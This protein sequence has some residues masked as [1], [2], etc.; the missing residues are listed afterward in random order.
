MSH[1][2]LQQLASRPLPWL[3]EIAEPGGIVVSSRVRLAR[4]LAGVPFPHRAAAGDLRGVLDQVRAAA[5]AGDGLGGATCFQLADLS[6]VERLVL[7]ERRL[8]SAD[9]NADPAERAVWVT[10]DETASLMVNEEDHLRLQVLLPGLRLGQA[11]DQARRLDTALLARLTPAYR[12]DLGFLTCCPTNLGTGLRASVMLHL[13]GLVLGGRIEPAVRALSRLGLAVRG[14]FGETQETVAHFVQI[15]NQSSLG[16]TEDEILANLEHYVRSLVW[17][18]E[19]A[20]KD[21]VRRQ[22]DLLY[23]HV[24]RAYAIVRYAYCLTSKEAL[25]CFSALRFGVELGLFGNLT[26]DIIQQLCRELPSGHLQMLQGTQ[27][28]SAVRDRWRAARARAALA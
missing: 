28:E 21:L 20:R 14:A 12:D 13:P 9:L 24:G 27:P 18:E 6:L 2:V 23:D 5:K 15:S 25:D 4:N 1:P 3:A 22:K 10:P 7:L 11:L 17:A 19:N 8:T 16:E 26:H